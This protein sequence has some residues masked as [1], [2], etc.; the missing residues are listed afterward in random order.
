MKTIK[1]LIS[2]FC[3]KPE[4]KKSLDFSHVD[5]TKLNEL[6]EY[7]EKHGSVSPNIN[8]SHVDKD[9]LNEFKKSILDIDNKYKQRV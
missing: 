6:K 3:K 2:W 4:Q 9:I 8:L 7:V 5:S 1:K